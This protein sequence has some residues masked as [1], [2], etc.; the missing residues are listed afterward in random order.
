MA[1]KLVKDRIYKISGISKV[2]DYKVGSL[3]YKR[4][5]SLYHMYKIT[6]KDYNEIFLKQKG[7]CAICDIHQV[8][9]DYVLNLD[10]CHKTMK[11]RGLL[12]KNCNTALGKFDDN[13]EL[14]QKAISYLN[15]NK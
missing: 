9:I 2:S 6:L 7:C 8:H 1:N 10:H 13:I 5:R 15:K 4:D 3:E 14:L 11:V 12:C